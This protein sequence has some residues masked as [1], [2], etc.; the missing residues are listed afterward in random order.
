MAWNHARRQ[1]ETDV[2]D[3][4]LLE[5]YR[6]DGDVDAVEELVERYRRPLFALIVRNA[7]TLNGADDIVQ[8]VWLRVLR[9]PGSFRGGSFTGWLF[10]IC[11][12]L[13]VDRFR[14]RRELNESDL[15]MGDGAGLIE[16]MVDPGGDPL[17]NAVRA[18]ESA[19]L[20]KVLE[21]LPLEQREVFVMRTQGGLRFRDIAVAQ[22]CSINT[23]LARMRYALDRIR[24]RMGDPDG[25]RSSSGGSAGD[26]GRH[27]P[28]VSERRDHE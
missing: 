27:G 3:S 11:R 12:N 22:G 4:V 8:E 2:T 7:G 17:G 19:R 16:A 25:A 21:T 9:N 18:E 23:V 26:S 1:P 28:G 14:K 24:V 6:R 10:R 20:Q 15:R 13:L 5:R